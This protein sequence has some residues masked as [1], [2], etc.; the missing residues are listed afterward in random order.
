MSS[1]ND[2]VRFED[3]KRLMIPKFAEER[4]A[5]SMFFHAV[6]VGFIRSRAAD[7]RRIG[8]Q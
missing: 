3:A 6:R 5:I 2:W 1:N 7:I 8:I 4:I